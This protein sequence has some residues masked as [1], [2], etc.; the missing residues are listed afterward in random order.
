MVLRH[1]VRVDV[2]QFLQQLLRRPV[3]QAHDLRDD[4][5]ARRLLERTRSLMYALLGE[6]QVAARVAQVA[7][8]HERGSRVA[9]ATG[10]RRV[11]GEEG[12]RGLRDG[13]LLCGGGHRSEEHTSE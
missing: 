1:A 9:E 13:V 3:E 5:R 2:D 10:S 8:R 4:L 6:L 11:A 12:S 7:V